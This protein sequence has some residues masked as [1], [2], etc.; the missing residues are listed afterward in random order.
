VRADRDAV[1]TE[2]EFLAPDR[3]AFGDT[4]QVDFV[5][6][7]GDEAAAG[8][9]VDEEPGSRWL[10]VLAAVVVLAL[11]AAGVVAAAPWADDA[12]VAPPSTTVAPRTTTDITAGLV[13]TPAGWVL[14][15]PPEGLRF[16]GAW[17]QMSSGGDATPLDIWVERADDPT[18]GRWLVVRWHDDLDSH[19][20]LDGYR[21]EVAGRSAVTWT[22]SSGATVVRA[23]APT[24]GV[25]LRAS[26]LSSD[27]LAA[28]VGSIDVDETSTSGIG[29]GLAEDTVP[30]GLTLAW[31]G[32]TDP[33]GPGV[34]VGAG[35][36]TSLYDPA[37]G[38]SMHISRRRVD[39]SLLPYRSLL[40]PAVAVPVEVADEMQSIGRPTSLY[41][42]SP[43]PD[44]R[45]L[46]A[47]SIDGDEATLIHSYDLDEATV[48]AAMAALRPAE[49]DEWADLVVRTNRGI[50]FDEGG[51]SPSGS[52]GGTL[53][54]GTA[55]TSS[56][57]PTFFWIRTDRQRWYTPVRVPYGAAVRRYADVDVDVVVVTSLWPNT[58]RTMRVTVGDAAPVDERLVQVGDGP[59]Y[60]GLIV[61]QQTGPISVELLDTAGNV[62]P[63]G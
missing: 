55:W 15:D 40:V 18:A 35:P 4:S 7:D 28:L 57:S 22:D 33:Y 47:A 9:D 30:P 46:V 6:F 42:V 12:V 14:D 29:Y 13:V 25:E 27:E 56:F 41:S 1:E 51:P 31:S 23:R 26:G 2:I 16:A 20:A 61:Q 52:L 50:A 37:D 34:F 45:W 48:L 53:A 59:I 3:R 21:F 5:G 62:V 8:F 17:S 19:L 63:V 60:V 43:T 24:G 11:I 38:T 44:E 10:T 36:V 49:P 32:T 58:A 39:P 54:D